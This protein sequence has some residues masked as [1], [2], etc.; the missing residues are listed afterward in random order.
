MTSVLYDK[1]LSQP[2]ETQ[3]IQL[4]PVYVYFR[5][6]SATFVSHKKKSN[7]RQIQTKEKIP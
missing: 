5:L 4:S 6:L 1:T 7:N 2:L 3:M